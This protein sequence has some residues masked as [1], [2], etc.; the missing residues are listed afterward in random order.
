MEEY[1]EV[2]AQLFDGRARKE[3][4][5][6]DGEWGRRLVNRG[7]ITVATTK[8]ATWTASDVEVSPTGEQTFTAHGPDGDL[9]I[10]LPLAGS[11]NVA[12]A[13][14]AI[15]CLH[16]GGHRRPRPSQ[17]GLANVQVPGRM[18][19]VDEGQ[20]FTAV[21][22]Y[23]HKPAAVALALDAVRAK[24]DGRVIIV[25]GC[26]GDRDTGQAPADG[27]GRRRTRRRVD[28]HR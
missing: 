28:H 12:N 9:R 2:K 21:V 25:L 7:T 8:P 18:Q 10:H 23:S 13:L 22:D 5:C 24:T 19:R 6:V 20:E 16:V 1:F 4:V 15:A 11:F 14:L 3:I 27:R 17:T 26:G